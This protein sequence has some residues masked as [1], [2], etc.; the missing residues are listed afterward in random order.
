MDE[1]AA[2]KHLSR[3]IALCDGAGVVGVACEKQGLDD[4]EKELLRRNS[5]V[6]VFR[7]QGA[8]DYPFLWLERQ[9]IDG[10]WHSFRKDS[11]AEAAAVISAFEK[12]CRRGLVQHT[13]GAEFVLTGEGFKIAQYEKQYESEW[14]VRE[15]ARKKLKHVRREAAL[16]WVGVLILVV[17]YIV[18]SQYVL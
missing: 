3:I 15:D 17:L 2:I 6:G 7:V 11:H 10:T 12:L 13:G 8:D 1:G 16:F 9:G 14:H 4:D 5:E 18:I